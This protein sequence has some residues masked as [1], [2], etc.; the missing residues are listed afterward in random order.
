MSEPLRAKWLARLGRPVALDFAFFPIEQ[1][2]ART[3]TETIAT[4]ELGTGTV[5]AGDRLEAVGHGPERLPVRI[6][7]I[8]APRPERHA[9]ETVETGSAGEA[10]GLAL[11]HAPDAKLVAGQCLAPPGRLALASRVEAEVWLLETADVPGSPAEHRRMLADLGASR[12][13]DCFF[14]T[15]DVAA[16]VADDWRPGFGAEYALAIELAHPVA[17]YPG[18]RFAVRYHGLTLGVGFIR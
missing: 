17:L 14:H 5:R 1:V 11:E 7:R 12:G 18:A 13:L 8:D 10:L 15:H 6:L 9:V 3:P 2:Y 16:R 4:G